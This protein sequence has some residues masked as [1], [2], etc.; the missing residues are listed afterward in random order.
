M[1]GTDRKT[2]A[3]R[4]YRRILG[5]VAEDRVVAAAEDIITDVWIG[6]LEQARRDIM[7][8]AEA[9]QADLH[10]VCL[11]L[12]AVDAEIERVCLVGVER[13]RRG[14]DE[15]FRLRAAWD[16]AYGR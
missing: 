3:E 5:E 2:E 8:S 4:V 12:E 9:D 10:Q 7:A 6:E 13:S 1:A 15:L 16:K 14:R 11:V